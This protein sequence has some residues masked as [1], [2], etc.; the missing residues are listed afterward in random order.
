MNTRTRETFNSLY[1]GMAYSKSTGL[2]AAKALVKH[3]GARYAMARRRYVGLAGQYCSDVPQAIL[4]AHITRINPSFDQAPTAPAIQDNPLIANTVGYLRIPLTYIKDA[5]L[6]ARMANDIEMCTWVWAKSF[7]EDSRYLY[8]TYPNLFP[9]SNE[10]FWRCAYAR[11]SLGD[12]LFDYVWS[13]SLVT[14]SHTG[15]VWDRITEMLEI[16]TKA[17]ANLSALQLKKYLLFEFEYVFQLAK[18]KG[19][20]HSSGFGKEPVPSQRLMTFLK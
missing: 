14:S 18:T 15:R 7:N 8:K 17:I 16:R 9:F 5:G 3:N 11:T 20:V 4:F 1:L 10:D 2:S 19:I 6:T 12:V 13:E